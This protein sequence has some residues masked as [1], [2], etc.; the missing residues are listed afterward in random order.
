MSF[1]DLEKAYNHVF[2]TSKMLHAKSQ[3]LALLLKCPRRKTGKELNFSVQL[4]A[5]IISCCLCIMGC[6]NFAVD[7]DPQQMLLFYL[8]SD[9]L[10]VDLLS[11]LQAH[12]SEVLRSLT[13]CATTH[14]A[15]VGLQCWS[16][17]LRHQQDLA[18]LT[19]PTFP[20]RDDFQHG[21]SQEDT[22]WKTQVPDTSTVKHI[23]AKFC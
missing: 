21:S 12:L 16:L 3:M 2:Y 22:L 11:Q 1:A 15:L 13:L 4:I 6:L 23:S 17:F 18:E 14:S 20:T 8:L 5:Q 9:T 10:H 19:G 7:L